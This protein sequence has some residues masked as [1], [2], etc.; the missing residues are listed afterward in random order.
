MTDGVPQSN[1]RLVSEIQRLAVAA[2]KIAIVPAAVDGS[3]LRRER[4]DEAARDG[5]DQGM[6]QV[7]FAPDTQRP[8]FLAQEQRIEA[9]ALGGKHGIDVL[10]GCLQLL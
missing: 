1:S 8:C 3:A 10:D 6:I 9:F 4:P 5:A 7:A 2:E